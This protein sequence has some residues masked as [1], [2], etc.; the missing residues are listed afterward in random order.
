LDTQSPFSGQTV[1]QSLS[2][3]SSSF[4]N[5]RNQYCRNQLI[6]LLRGPV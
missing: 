5:P 4:P 6:E 1:H 2:Q 3:R